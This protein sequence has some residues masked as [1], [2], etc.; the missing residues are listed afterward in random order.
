MPMEGSASSNKDAL[1]GVGEGLRTGILMAVPSTLSPEQHTPISPYTA[2]LHP[3]EPRVS[4]C[5]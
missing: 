5:K 1:C 2:R 3:P 4:G